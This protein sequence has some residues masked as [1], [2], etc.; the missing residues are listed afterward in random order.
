[1]KALHTRS[2]MGFIGALL[3]GGFWLAAALMLT[4]PAQSASVDGSPAVSADQDLA[5]YQFPF[6]INE[7][8]TGSIAVASPIDAATRAQ[9]DAIFAGESGSIEIAQQPPAPQPNDSPISNAETP[10][11]FEPGAFVLDGR[12]TIATD[13]AGSYTSPAYPVPLSSVAPF[14]SVGTIWQVDNPAYYDALGISVQVRGSVDGQTWTDWR[15]Y[16][17]FGLSSVGVYS[18]LMTFDPAT[19]YVQFQIV[20]DGTVL[21]GDLTISGGKLVFINPGVTPPA[22]QAQIDAAAVSG[23]MVPAAPDPVTGLA[24]NRPSV[25]SRTQ[26][27]CPQGQSS[28]AWSPTYRTVTHFIIH[29]TVSDNVSSDWPA[30]VRSIWQYHTYNNGWGDIGYNF[31]IDPN[32][33]VYEG[34]AGGDEAVGGHFC[35][36][37]G[38]TMGVAMLG[39]YTSR[40]PSQAAI[41][42]LNNLLAWKADEFG[43]DP[44]G[45]S[46]HAASGLTLNNISGHRDGCQTAC[47]GNGMYNVIPSVRSNVAAMVGSGTGRPG[48][49]IISAPAEDEGVAVPFSVILQPGQ[50]NSTGRSDFWIQIDNNNNF[51][52]PEFDNV[53]QNGAWTR[54][55]TIPVTAS[56]TPG[57]YYLRARQ[58][59]TVSRD[60]DWTATVRFTVRAAPENDQFVGATVIRTLPATFTQDAYLAGVSSTDPNMSCGA[61]G[62]AN[63]LWFTYTA[64]TPQAVRLSTA[65]S[66]YDTAIAVYVISNGAF[67]EIGCHDD[68]SGSDKTSR[69]TFTTYPGAPY[70]IMVAKWGARALTASTNLNLTVTAPGHDAF[71]DSI[72]LPAGQRA[73]SHDLYGA[74]VAGSDPGLSCLGGNKDYVNSV[75]YRYTPNVNGPVLVATPGN[76]IDAVLAVFTGNEGGLSE[77]GCNDNFGGTTASLVRFEATAGTT[78]HILAARRGSNPISA[79]T[80]LTLNINLPTLLAPGAVTNASLGNPTYVWGDVGADYYYLVVQNNAGQQVVNEVIRRSSAACDQTLCQFDAAALR[81]R[82]RLTD[83]AYLVWLNS[84]KNGVPGTVAGPYSFALDAPPPALAAMSAATDTSTL[85]PTIRWTLPSGSPQLAT[86]FRLYVAPANNLGRG[87]LFTEVSRVAACGSA[88]GTT[89]GYTP[90]FDFADNT[91]YNAFVQSCGAGGC[92]I[93]GGPYNN[94]YAG[95]AVFTVDAPTPNLPHP[96]TVSYEDGFPVIRWPDDTKASSFN[97]VIGTQG[98]ASFPFFQNY[99]RTTGA[100]GLCDGTTCRVTVQIALANAPYNFAVQ[101]VSAGG[102]SVGGPYANGYAVVE[103]QTLNLSTPTPVVNFTAPTGDIPT[104]KPTFT[105]NTVAGATR[106]Q[107]WVGTVTPGFTTLHLQPYWATAPICTPHPGTCTVTP[108]LRLNARAYAWNVQSMGPGGNSEWGTGMAFNVTGTL[109]G[110]VTLLAPT[111]TTDT[112]SPAFSWSDLNGVER[113]EVWIGNTA[114]TDTYHTQRYNRADICAAGT[115]TITP[116]L[117]LLNGAHLWNVRAESPA[118]VGPWVPNGMRFTVSVAAPAAPALVAPSNGA[119]IHATNRPTFIWN[120]V[121]NSQGYYLQVMNGSFQVIYERIHYAADAECSAASCLVQLP[122]AIAYGA[123]RWRVVPGNINGPGASTDWR[124]FFSLSVNAEPMVADAGDALVERAGDWQAQAAEMTVEGDYLENPLAEEGDALTLTF[125]GTQVDLLYVAA[126]DYD[127]FDIEIDGVVV[128]TVEAYAPEVTVGLIATVRDLAEGTHT[129]RILAR[130]KIGIDAVSVDGEIIAGTVPTP[131]ASPTPEATAEPTPEETPQPEATPEL[132][133]STAEPTPES[134]PDA[135]PEVTPEGT[136]NT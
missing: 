117:S 136:P 68:A 128:Q 109:P 71:G 57:T 129:L 127:R 21:E 134:T 28:P 76:T 105:W 7:D 110:T 54:E 120:T 39:T 116:T 73:V 30:Q 25:V 12:L 123:Y 14:L 59:D 84:W 100:N 118:G 82:Y 94:G 131:T 69:L 41:N 95:T 48:I 101:G 66:G 24:Y 61:E 77:V 22:Q 34:R 79:P 70:Y 119:V 60:S 114:V 102:G 78:Y 4:A 74:T 11:T 18:D 130:G 124:D 103:N 26:W 42:A 9:V 43:I 65:G 56:L 90:T 36:Q 31:V 72:V 111:T 83:G 63:T 50:T 133:E 40:A 32:G 80:V 20:W 106:Y 115:C 2:G 125:I 55:T 3:V 49:P 108:D 6:E 75:W 92:T 17:E 87:T 98:W 85:R 23:G 96:V 19:R 27:G 53:R 62:R 91:T 81:E 37:N 1:M 35:G 126:P 58:G 122:N 16:E 113:Y 112:Y 38:G 51:S 44:D 13:G 135:A 132:P 104:S 64:N 99:P 52:S 93:T 8:Q 33:V 121:A 29:H 10:V 47:P 88:S 45:R 5:A 97:V 15:H 46:Y 107:L 89:C 86:S 67:V